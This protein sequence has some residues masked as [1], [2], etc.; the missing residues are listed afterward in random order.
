MGHTEEQCNAP[1]KN[2]APAWHL[3]TVDSASIPLGMPSTTHAVVDTSITTHNLISLQTSS[4]G[5]LSWQ[6]TMKQRDLPAR[7]SAWCLR[8]SAS[9]GQ[10]PIRACR[11]WFISARWAAN[12]ANTALTGCRHQGSTYAGQECHASD[13]QLER[14]RQPVLAQLASCP[15]RRRGDHTSL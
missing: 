14:H 9:R 4:P 13:M 5:R 6:Q 8:H 2:Q 1:T 12:V 11:V 3:Y 7:G 15:T 10:F